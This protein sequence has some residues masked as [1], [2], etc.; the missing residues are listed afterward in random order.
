[1]LAEDVTE[2]WL[3]KALKRLPSPPSFHLANNNESAPLALAGAPTR[4][5]SLTSL[6]DF[7]LKTVAAS[8]KDKKEQRMLIENVAQPRTQQPNRAGFRP[9][10]G[11]PDLRQQQTPSGDRKQLQAKGALPE[12]AVGQPPEAGRPADRRRHGCPPVLRFHRR[13]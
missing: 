10:H 4:V 1:S 7:Q 9:P 8:G 6:E 2:G 11:R 5:P 3:G 12:H 13:L